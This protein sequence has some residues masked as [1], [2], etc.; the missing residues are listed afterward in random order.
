MVGYQ[1]SI[2]STFKI[3]SGYERLIL[4]PKNENITENLGYMGNS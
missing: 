3:H 1:I 4:L 2:L